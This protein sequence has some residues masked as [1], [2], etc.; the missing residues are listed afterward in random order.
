MAERRTSH[1][2]ADAPHSNGAALVGDDSH[3][4][5]DATGSNTTAF[6]TWGFYVGVAGDVK[7]DLVNGG[8]VVF[9]A[10][11]VGLYQ[12]RIKRFYATGT[13]ATNVIGLA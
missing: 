6:N 2:A 3:D 7:V 10:M 1:I 12:I 5:G 13:T 8:T 9:K 4:L 11:P